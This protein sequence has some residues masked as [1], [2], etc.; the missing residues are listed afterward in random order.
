MIRIGDVVRLRDRDGYVVEGWIKQVCG[1]RCLFCL[2]SIVS[3]PK[4]RDF[5]PEWWIDEELIYA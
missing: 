3:A 5:A 4:K 1:S 2:I